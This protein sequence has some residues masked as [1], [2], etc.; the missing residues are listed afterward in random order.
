MTESVL[1]RGGCHCGAVRFEA[2]LREM[3]TMVA[4][5]LDFMRGLGGHDLAA[6]GIPDE[7]GYVHRYCERSGRG[8][9]GAVMRDWNFYLAYNLFRLGAILQG[10]AGR[11]KDGTAAS[12]QAKAMGDAAGPLADLGW[13]Q[14]EKI[15]SRR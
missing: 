7:L 15:L 12:A 9:V 1:H 2:D 5:T 4:Q 6:L 14:V 13:A 11:V 8:D 10:I 3:E